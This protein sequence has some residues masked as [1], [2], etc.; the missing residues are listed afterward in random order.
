MPR[1]RSMHPGQWTDERFVT[2]SPLA[3]LLAIGVR[4]EADDNGIFE[5]K[6]LTL[7]MRLFP[8]DNCDVSEMLAELVETEQVFRYRVGNR[9]YGI[10]RN[11]TKFQSPKKPSFYHPVPDCPLPDGYALHSSFVPNCGPNTATG[12]PTSSPPVPHQSGNPSPE[13]IG[14]GEGKGKEKKHIGSSGDDPVQTKKPGIPKKGYTPEFEAAWGDYPKRLGGNS[15]QDAYRAWKARLNQGATVEAMHDG[16]KRYAQ[17]CENEGKTGTQWVRQASVF[18]GPGMHFE[19]EWTFEV[20]NQSRAELKIPAGTDMEA[21]AELGRIAMRIEMSSEDVERMRKLPI[22]QAKEFL[23]SRI[24]GH[25]GGGVN[26][27]F[28][29]ING[30]LAA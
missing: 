26:T 14:I 9:E 19:A 20:A 25:P 28:R 8:A 2:C 24:G 23:R 21:W 7:K 16:I 17:F 11:F 29:V 13:G 5:W 15:K 10:I 1:I 4:N 12:F 6:P 18:L 30:G 3:R 27:G 22:A